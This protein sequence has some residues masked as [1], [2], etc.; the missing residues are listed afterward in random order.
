LDTSEIKR[1]RTLPTGR[2]AVPTEKLKTFAYDRLPAGPLRDLILSEP[3]E[4]P[5]SE[6]AIKISVYLKLLGRIDQ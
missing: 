3:N 4:L 6:L 5:A 2:P 1:E